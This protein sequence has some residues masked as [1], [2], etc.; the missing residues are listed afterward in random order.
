[1]ST[2]TSAEQA[3]TL[4]AKAATY[5]GAGASAFGGFFVSSEGLALLGLLVAVGGFAVNLWLGLR[6]DRREDREHRARM[7]ELE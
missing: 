7:R 1:M 6:R 3:A 2:D 4:A 5:G